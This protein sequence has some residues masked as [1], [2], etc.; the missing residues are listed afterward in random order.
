MPLLHLPEN[1]PDPMD[2][3]RDP[4]WEANYPALILRGIYNIMERE[5]KSGRGSLLERFTKAFNI[6]ILTLAKR[7]NPRRIVINNGSIQLTTFGDKQNEMISGNM[8]FD[9]KNKKRYGNKT[10]AEMKAETRKIMKQ[11]KIWIN[12]LAQDLP[13][14]QPAKSPTRNP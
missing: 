5:G 7:S 9:I 1:Y 14:K 12:S 8:R 6:I 13:D 3:I 4:K 10:R 11:L 2:L